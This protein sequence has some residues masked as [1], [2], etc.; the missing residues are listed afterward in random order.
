[1]TDRQRGVNELFWFVDTGRNYT[2]ES[3]KER[4]IAFG[5]KVGYEE[6][7]GPVCEMSLENVDSVPCEEKGTPCPK[8]CPG[9]GSGTL[10]RW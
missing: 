2:C 4:A 7:F 10:L 3:P 5:T 1:M 8:D 9:G 6:G